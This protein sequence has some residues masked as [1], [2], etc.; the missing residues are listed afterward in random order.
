MKFDAHEWKRP[1]ESLQLGARPRG[2]SLQGFGHEL[3]ARL[4]QDVCP[5]AT[6]EYFP[7]VVN[8]LA[9]LWDDPEALENEFQRLLREDRPDGSGF[10]KAIIEELASVRQWRLEQRRMAS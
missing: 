6:A 2:E 8:R 4:P 10:P 7:H 9:W 3:L 5:Y 1:H